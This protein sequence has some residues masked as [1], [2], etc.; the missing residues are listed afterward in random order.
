MQPYR[1][2][3]RSHRYPQGVRTNRTSPDVGRVVACNRRVGFG[4]AID[5]RNILCKSDR[6]VSRSIARE[7]S[8]NLTQRLCHRCRT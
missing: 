1:Q 3:R 6:G 2:V 8:T 7:G 5:I 4:G